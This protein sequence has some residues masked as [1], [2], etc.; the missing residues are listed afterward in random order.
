MRPCLTIFAMSNKPPPTEE[1]W[2]P[3]AQAAALLGFT[4]RTLLTYR[5]R[6]DFP[7]PRRSDIHAH[8]WEWPETALID[9]KANRKRRH[10]IPSPKNSADTPEKPAGPPTA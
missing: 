4:R 3:T 1:R 9:W 5:Y 2:L 6:D 10:A 8:T 7:Q